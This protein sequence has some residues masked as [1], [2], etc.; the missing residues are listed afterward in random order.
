MVNVDTY[1]EFKEKIEQGVFIMA[2][3]DGTPETEEKIK[4]ET[5]ATIRC[6]PLEGDKTPGK[7]MVTGKPSKCRVLFARAY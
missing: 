5:K 7:C 1:E 3:W 6:I 2:H 4:N